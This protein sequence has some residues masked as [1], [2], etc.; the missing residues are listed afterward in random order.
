MH[1]GALLEE[2]RRQPLSLSLPRS[3]ALSLSHTLVRSPRSCT[4]SLSIS[5]SASSCLARSLP[6]SRTLMLSSGACAHCNVIHKRCGAFVR[7]SAFE[8]RGPNRRGGAGASG[9]MCTLVLSSRRTRDFLYLFLCLGLS[10]S[11]SLAPWC[12]PRVQHDTQPLR[13]SCARQ[14][15]RGR[16]GE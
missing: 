16:G 13:C 12:C 14:C 11:S 1:V 2:E 9:K 8:A 15:L 3:L 5:I 4:P 6:L 10:L 7:D